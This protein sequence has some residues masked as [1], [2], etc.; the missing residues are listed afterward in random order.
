MDKEL[1]TTISYNGGE[2]LTLPGLN[3]E[4]LESFNKKSDASIMVYKIKATKEQKKRIIEKINEINNAG[5]AYN[6]VGLVTKASIRPNIMFC[7]QFVYSILKIANLEYF[8]ANNTKVKP[9]DFVENDYY[10][11]LEFCYEIAF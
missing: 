8:E 6:L 10:R 7:S 1:K 5:S 2:N 9:T 4:Q 11:K 3:Q